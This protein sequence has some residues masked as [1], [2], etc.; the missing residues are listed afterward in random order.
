MDLLNN[1]SA[2]EYLLNYRDGKIKHGLELG[3]GL[4]DYLKFKKNK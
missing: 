4:D 3:N 2:L 1:G